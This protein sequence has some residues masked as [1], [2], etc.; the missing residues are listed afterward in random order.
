MPS[1]VLI[2]DDHPSFRAT[3]RLLLEGDGYVV[4]G[5]AAD[6]ASALRA[7]A[8]LEPDVVLL[9]VNL[10]DL[11]GFAVA[12]RLTAG[13]GGPRVVLCSSRDA[14]DFGDLVAG[15]GARGF[16]AKADLSGAAVREL[17]G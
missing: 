4:V 3:A 6:G 13:G 1:T 10:P 8:E 5:E 11:D 12:E 9:D 17:V 2:V 16:V 14:E 15:S 7:A